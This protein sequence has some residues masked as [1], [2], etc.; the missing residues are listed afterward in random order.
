MSTIRQTITEF[1]P[2]VP[3]EHSNLVENAITLLEDRENAI[4]GNLSAYAESRGLSIYE[5]DKILR[6][7]GLLE[8]EPEPVVNVTEQADGGMAEVARR[9]E[10]TLLRVNER[11]TSLEDVAASARR[12]GLLA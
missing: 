4:I 3:A 8:P 1:L 9:I 12:R 6:D 5:I 2:P 7:A 11:L 10:Q